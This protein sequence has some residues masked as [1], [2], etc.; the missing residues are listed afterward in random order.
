MLDDSHLRS[1]TL[2]DILVVAP[3]S[4]S[5]DEL[6]AY[7]ESCAPAL[8]GCD[9]VEV[10]P[11]QR[12]T[13]GPG[14]HAGPV[15][16]HVRS[17]SVV[18]D[19]EPWGELR[20]TYLQGPPGRAEVRRG[21]LLAAVLGVALL[22]VRAEQDA[23]SATVREPAAT[24]VDTGRAGPDDLVD[25]VLHCAEVLDL[26]PDATTRARL[27]LVTSRVAAAV[28]A[29]SWCV[30][31]AHHGRLHDVAR[32]GEPTGAEGDGVGGTTG[33]R[34]SLLS[35]DHPA[36]MRASEGGVFRA[37]RRTGDDAE[38]RAL[39]E[40]G[41][42]AVVGAGGYDLDGRSW[43]VAVFADCGRRLEGTP[44]VL[45]SLVLAALSFPREAVVPRPVEPS[46]RAILDWP[47]A[48]DGGAGIPGI[49]EAG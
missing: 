37:D 43:V 14:D 17:H 42:E 38:R 35:S 21:R 48:G 34:R 32:A 24:D 3:S 49:G 18:C 25:V 20:L 4:P 19:G 7:V 47:A 45:L 15:Q 28:G 10:R 26:M 29:S 8:V 31:V 9:E 13:G 1:A 44:A 39:V 12:A 22:S 27:A 5:L 41:H 33:S 6:L 2:T 46:V 30:E 16:G 23:S 11:G 40:G 36:R